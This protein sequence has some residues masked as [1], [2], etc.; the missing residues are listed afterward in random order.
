MKAGVD[1]V[2][3]ALWDPSQY[4]GFLNEEISTVSW[5]NLHRPP[6]ISRER[7]DELLTKTIVIGRLLGQELGIIDSGGGT[8]GSLTL[9]A[10]YLGLAGH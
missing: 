8:D 2:N 9:A 7:S 5:V 4:G 1:L 3:Q 6:K 10:T